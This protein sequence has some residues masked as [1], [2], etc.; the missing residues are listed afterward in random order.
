ME[1]NIAQTVEII[2]YFDRYRFPV[3]DKPNAYAK[4]QRLSDRH[5]TI[6]FHTS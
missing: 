2:N 1:P 3:Y 4:N 5:Q 6:R